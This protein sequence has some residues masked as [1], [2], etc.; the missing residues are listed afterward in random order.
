MK[1]IRLKL[2][3]PFRGLASGYEVLFVESKEKISANMEPIC[4][5][6]LNGSGK[7]NVLEVISEIFYFLERYQNASKNEQKKFKT[8]FGFEIEYELTALHVK[9]AQTKWDELNSFLDNNQSNPIIK[10]IKQIDQ[11]PLISAIIENQIFS[12]K[13][14]AINQLEGILPA[15]V[16][17]YSSGM[18]ELLSNPFIKMS[19]NYFDKLNQ[20][21]WVGD[22]IEMNRMFFLDY[23]SNKIIAICNFLFDKDDFN[24]AARF[25]KAQKAI[26]FGA[27]DLRVIKNELKLEDIHS[28]IIKIKLKKNTNEK[29]FL[30]SAFA[31]NLAKLE[32]CTP[33]IKKTEWKNKTSN[34]LEIELEYRINNSSKICFREHFKTPFD[35]FKVFYYFQLLNVKLITPHTRKII[36]DAKAGSSENLGD[37]LPKFENNNLIFRISALTFK[38]KNKALLHYRQLSDG[39]HQFLQVFGS[40]ILM[41][42]SDALFLLD[43]PET[44]FNP[45]WRSKFIFNL[46]KSFSEKKAKSRNQEILITTHSPYIISDC[47]KENVYIFQSNRNGYVKQPFQPSINTFGTSVDILTSLIFGKS[48]SISELSKNKIEEILKMPLTTLKNV[49]AAKEASRLL[50]ESIEKVLLFK[51]LITIENELKK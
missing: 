43:E 8:S 1:L 29:E 37:E 4:F 6:G 31:L 16:I 40:L 9:T 24:M 20:E 41:D 3:T 47:K 34:F 21:L 22:N 46:N 45:D 38:K 23:D 5:V 26:E 11:Y 7:S 51:E 50:G 13:N 25:S 30:P 42:T 35:L 32:K 12:L 36:L 18:N 14:S 33:F 15:R 44:H 49:K 28:F 27:K 39:E 19:F 10:I 17:A 2:L 48:D